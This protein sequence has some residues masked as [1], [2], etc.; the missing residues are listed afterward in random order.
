MKRA[1]TLAAVVGVSLIL[2]AVSIAGA[3][4]GSA[5]SN[6]SLVHFD[7]T[8]SGGWVCTSSSPSVRMNPGDSLRLTWSDSQPY[9]SSAV[10]QFQGPVSV[11]V[12]ISTAAGGTAS[13]ST[14][15][16]YTLN[17]P[18]A[19]NCSLTVSVVSEPVAAPE[20]HDYLQ[21]V[22]VPASGNCADV[23]TWVGHLP[24]FPIGG[25]GRSWAQWIYDG[26]GGPV[27]TRVVETRPDGTVIVLS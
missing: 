2:T 6:P 9:Q 1:R 7:T 17:S 19:F 26:Q 18:T 3:P 14:L 11:D 10:F 13:F 21:Q 5:A 12:P 24:G 20:A 8:Y 15:G 22:G 27:C 25:W 23:P 4:A 16:T